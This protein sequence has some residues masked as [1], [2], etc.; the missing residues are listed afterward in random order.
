MG[1]ESNPRSP[2]YV[3]ALDPTRF[4][5]L[6]PMV[7]RCDPKIKQRE[8]VV[9][10]TT[11]HMWVCKACRKPNLLNQDYVPIC[12][13]CENERLVIWIYNADNPS[14]TC[15]SCGGTNLALPNQVTTD[16]ADEYNQKLEEEVTRELA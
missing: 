7:C 16:F 14:N 13:W 9:L 1:Y 2:F 11:R 6:W 5:Y 15:R 12:I 4:R 3:P 8:G 10:D